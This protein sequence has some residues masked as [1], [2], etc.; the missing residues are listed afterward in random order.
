MVGLAIRLFGT[1]W[2]K[3]LEQCGVGQFLTELPP[4]EILERKLQDS[5][6]LCRAL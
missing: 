5:I 6:A 1:F 4:K 3:W 2:R